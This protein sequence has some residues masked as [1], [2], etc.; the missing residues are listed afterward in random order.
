MRGPEHRHECGCS[1]ESEPF[2]V[3]LSQVAQLLG[4]TRQQVSTWKSRRERNGFPK[5]CGEYSNGELY[6]WEEVLLWYQN[7]TPRKG[8]A[9]RGA[10]NGRSR[11]R[12]AIDH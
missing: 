5:A 10:R 2:L 8:G 1:V 9:P 4:K 11:Y 7:Y 12:R 6:L 3:T